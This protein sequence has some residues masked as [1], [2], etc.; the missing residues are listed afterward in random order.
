MD[1]SIVEVRNMV[2]Q[3]LDVPPEQIDCSYELKNLPTWDS[4]TQITLILKIEKHTGQSLTLQQ[5]CACT[6]VVDFARLLDMPSNATS[7]RLH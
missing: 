1:S 6:S 5:I 4:I 3:I 7:H 2:A